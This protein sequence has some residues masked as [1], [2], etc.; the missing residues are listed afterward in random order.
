MERQNL[1][2]NYTIRLGPVG[3]PHQYIVKSGGVGCR[4][5][6]CGSPLTVGLYAAESGK[7][8]AKTAGQSA[9][10]HLWALF[11]GAESGSYF[12]LGVDGICSFSH[13]SDGECDQ[14]WQK[15][16]RV[17]HFL[18]QSRSSVIMSLVSGSSDRARG[19]LNY[20]RAE[21]TAMRNVCIF[22]ALCDDRGEKRLGRCHWGPSSVSPTL[23][24]LRWC[25]AKPP[26]LKLNCQ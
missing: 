19:G 5:G 9:I 22:D 13:G 25:S 2:T 7:R 1:P 26:P 16:A 11:Q 10:Q 4:S 8:W 17:P 3:T 18:V 20:W 15:K 23:R 24:G 6:A 14:G 12:E 21:Q